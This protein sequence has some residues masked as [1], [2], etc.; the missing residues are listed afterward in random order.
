MSHLDDVRKELQRRNEQALIGGGEERIKKQH[1]EGKLTA[2]ERLEILLDEGSFIELDRLR[3]H[4]CTDFGME[5]KKFYGDAVVTGYGM[6]NGRP[7]AV[8]F[9]GFY[10]FWWHAFQGFC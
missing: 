7:V 2:R 1:E 3:V 9:P 6:I 10:C 5:K 4:D 8:F